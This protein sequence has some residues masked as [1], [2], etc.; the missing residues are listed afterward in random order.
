MKDNNDR[1]KYAQLY[2]SAVACIRQHDI[3]G[4]AAL[5][6]EAQKL[7]GDVI[8]VK[9]MLSSC[10]LVLGDYQQAVQCWQEI[11]S[12]DPKNKSA[13]TQLEMHNSP[14]HQFWIKRYLE[15]VAEVEKKNYVTAS[16]ILRSLLEEKDGHVA[17]YQLLGLCYLANEQH[18]EAM[19]MWQ[20]GLELDQFNPALLEYLHLLP[21]MQ[22][23][24]LPV[25]D[26][27]AHRR[28]LFGQKRLVWAASVII[29]VLLAVPGV[30]LL[31]RA[32]HTDSGANAPAV[33]QPEKA[34]A[35]ASLEPEEDLSDD[36]LSENI[37]PAQA[38]YDIKKEEKYYW[39]GH[40]AYNNR[41]WK[42][43]AHNYKMVVDMSTG[44]YLNREA[45]YYLARVNYVRGELNQAEPYYIKY[46]KEFPGTAYYDDTLFYLGC[47]YA[48]QNQTERAVEVFRQLKNVAPDSGYLTANIYK[49]IMD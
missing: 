40:Q 11:L 47:I 10:Y 26:S 5:L 35:L 6:L 12:L 7:E 33:T 17:L 16:S 21:G 20:K 3:T 23:E 27:Q 9:H 48:Q 24:A 28:S 37:A 29:V 42:S 44:S 31:N 36:T 19:K 39:A 22:V 8:K 38:G 2:D 41:D 30:F 45:L 4:A 13:H 14:S 46:L 43:A 49:K 15:A 18:E 32:A 1:E 25:K 34:S